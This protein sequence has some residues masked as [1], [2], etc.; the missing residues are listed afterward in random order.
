VFHNDATGNLTRSTI[1]THIGGRRIA[2]ASPRKPDSERH[3]SGTCSII[4][5]DAVCS[6]KEIF[7]F[8]EKVTEELPKWAR[9]LSIAE[10]NAARRSAP[11]IMA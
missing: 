8:E 9:D 1:S 4:D 10:G 3:V 7:A 2:K 11:T 5:D 6:I